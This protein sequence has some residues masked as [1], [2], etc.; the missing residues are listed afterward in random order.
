MAM[1]VVAGIGTNLVLQEVPDE[2]VFSKLKC[3][4]KAMVL[5]VWEAV[6]QYLIDNN[7][8]DLFLMAQDFRGTD[9][10]F[11][12]G[13]KAVKTLLGWTDEQVE[14]FLSDCVAET[15]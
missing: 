15:V 2:R 3:V 12:R 14:D 8:Y 11:K 4:R 5:D 1:K 13:I 10:D 9:P 7:F 6:K